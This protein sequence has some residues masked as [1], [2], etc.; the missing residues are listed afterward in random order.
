MRR[1]K[2]F[3]DFKVNNITIDDVIKCI[4][5]G[6]VIYTSIV[7]NLPNNDPKKPLKVVDIDNNGLATVEY[8][9]SEYTVE[10]NNIEKIEY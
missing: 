7:K 5:K 10:L 1:I 4:K 9:G 3:E 6:G 2:L 8:D